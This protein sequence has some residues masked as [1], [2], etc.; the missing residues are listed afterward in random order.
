MSRGSHNVGVLLALLYGYVL[1]AHLPILSGAL[2]V[3]VPVLFVTV[4]YYLA[5]SAVY[6]KR[7][8]AFLLLISTT[9]IS[10]FFAYL[11]FGQVGWSEVVASQGEG[12]FAITLYS[13]LFVPFVFFAFVADFYKLAQEIASV[14]KARA[15][16][17]VVPVLVKRELITH[18]FAVV[19]DALEARGVDTKAWYRK[20]LLLP[21][22][23][24]PL[25]ITTLMEGVESYEYNRMLK[26]DILAYSPSRN[27]LRVSLPQRALLAVGLLLLT[28][29]PFV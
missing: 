3:A 15:F 17:L 1:Q 29:R 5:C 13:T 21:M 26:T 9:F 2:G 19:M 10:L 23:I 7:D 27:R 11:T 20:Y 6:R 12:W 22:W 14:T 8:F 18:R 25:T 24:V 28:L 16:Y 4:A